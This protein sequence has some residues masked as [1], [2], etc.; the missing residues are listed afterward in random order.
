MSAQKPAREAAQMP[1]HKPA[2]SLSILK[3]LDWIRTSASS[4][5]LI[6]IEVIAKERKNTLLENGQAKPR[7]S[8]HQK[9]SR[10]HSYWYRTRTLGGKQTTEYVGKKLPED[11]DPSLVRISHRDAHNP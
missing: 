11:L 9:L 5:D 10:G 2:R 3:V 7:E 8:Y 1:A 4:D 6:R